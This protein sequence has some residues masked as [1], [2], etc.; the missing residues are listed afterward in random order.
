MAKKGK[1]SRVL[2]NVPISAGEV[3][4][5]TTAKQKG[6]FYTGPFFDKNTYYTNGYDDIKTYN[7]DIDNQ[8]GRDS[9]AVCQQTPDG[10]TAYPMCTIVYGVPYTNDPKNPSRCI[11][12]IKN[13]CPAE[14]VQGTNCIRSN[15]MLPPPVAMNTRCDDRNTD[16]FMIPNYH[17]GNKY[18]FV[19]Q[20]NDPSKCMKPCPGEKVPGYL[21]DPVDG[22]SAGVFSST[23]EVDRC[24]SKDEYM[25]G[26]Y[27]GTGNFCPVSWVYRL[28]L[29]KEE[30]ITEIK[31]TQKNEN[32]TNYKSQQNITADADR[33]YLESKTML[34]NIDMPVKEALTACSQLNTPERVT[35]AYNMCHGI[36]SKPNSINTITRDKNQKIV[37]KQACHAMFCNEQDDLVSM[38]GRNKKPLCFRN[39]E[40]LSNASII[41][42]DDKLERDMNTNAYIDRVP[43]EADV[44]KNVDRGPVNATRIIVTSVIVFIVF[45]FSV[46]IYMI[47]DKISPF[48]MRIVC[49]FKFAFMWPWKRKEAMGNNNACFNIIRQIDKSSGSSTFGNFPFPTGPLP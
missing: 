39:L 31:G 26:K 36:Y 44:N 24:Y 1:K 23:T 49:F 15:V 8:D 33:M 48:V 16:W 11:I 20:G 43:E 35:K 13:F 3:C 29:K 12:D 38:V 5:I 47:R 9:N 34:E 27:A 19:Q 2:P 28:G 17:L 22:S 37:L 41:K 14:R 42:N 30:L 46:F 7:T 10:K 32:I 18:N 25:N 4:S 40:R 45:M 21:Q 6:L